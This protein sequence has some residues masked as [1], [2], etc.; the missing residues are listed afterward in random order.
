LISQDDSAILDAYLNNADR[1]L[2][3]R[4]VAGLHGNGESGLVH[5]MSIVRLTGKVLLGSALGA[6]IIG[7]MLLLSAWPFTGHVESKGRIETDA[8][9]LADLKE[10]QDQSIDTANPMR[11]QVDVDYRE[12]EAAA[13]FPKGEAPVLAAMVAD[14]FAAGS[15]TGRPRTAGAAWR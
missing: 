11:I 13:W 9:L 5:K 4:Q 3:N 12:G 7:A 6:V 1:C 8:G 10:I 14:G 2:F 15:G